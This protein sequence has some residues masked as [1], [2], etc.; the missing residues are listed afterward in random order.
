VKESHAMAGRVSVILNA[1]AGVPATAT[2]DLGQ[3]LR[4]LFQQQGIAPCLALARSGSEV[5]RLAQQAVQAR[6]P[7]VVAGG[8]DGTLN[9]VASALVG[10]EVA[11]GVLPL[12]TLNHFAK[13]LCIPLDLASAVHTI[14]A[15]W[16]RRVDVGEVNG[17][18]FL[19]NSSLGLYP[20]LVRHRTKQQ[21]R[22][23]RGKW[24]AFL[25][26]ALTLFQ[27]YPFLQVRLCL[28]GQALVRRTPFVFIGNN[29]YQLDLFN[30]GARACLDAGAFSVYVTHRTGRLGLLLLAVRAL[31]GRLHT[32][33]DFDHW[34][35]PEV[36]IDTRDASARGHRRRSEGDGD[37]ATLP[38]ASRGLAGHRA[39][40]RAEWLRAARGGPRRS[41][42]RVLQRAVITD[43]GQSRVVPYP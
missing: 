23:G 24:P 37:A 33:T 22:L 17:H 27:R 21:E 35:I 32:A 39:A 19:N 40:G 15:G 28:E 18:I 42:W 8:G 36:R 10:T 31:F 3:R 13:D 9:A 2:D 6:F 16:T 1:S 14:R 25:W 26:A 43:T 4:D 7:T 11:L 34:C 38:D 5:R 29:V 12:G 30:L 41:W 20:R